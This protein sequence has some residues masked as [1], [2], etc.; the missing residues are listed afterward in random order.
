MKNILNKLELLWVFLG[1]SAGSVLITWPLCLHL[2]TS[3]IGGMGDNIYFV[4]LIRWYQKVFLEGQGHPF[5]NPL[6]NY[7]QGW[8]LSTTETA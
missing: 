3:V 1:F 8:N 6:M 4:W 7:P 2:K 5:F